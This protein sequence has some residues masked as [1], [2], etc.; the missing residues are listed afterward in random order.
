MV[1]AERRLAIIIRTTRASP[2]TTLVIDMLRLAHNSGSLFLMGMATR[3]GSHAAN[4]G[5]NGDLTLLP[6][7]FATWPPNLRN[8]GERACWTVTHVS[9]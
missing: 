1:I 4:P 5:A 8:R 3:L 7:G 6:G 2:T 9:C